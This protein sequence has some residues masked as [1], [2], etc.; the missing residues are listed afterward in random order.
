MMVVF[1][2][3]CHIVFLSHHNVLF[4]QN[5][6]FQFFLVSE[7]LQINA[8]LHT[9]TTCFLFLLFSN[10]RKIRI[11]PSSKRILVKVM[12]KVSRT[13]FTN[14]SDQSTWVWKI[15][16]EFQILKLSMNFKFC[17]SFSVTICA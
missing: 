2:V 14:S 9:V 1:Q 3:L 7:N 15:V 10:H 4:N 13:S 11:S 16:H 17:N 8:F 12:W 6:T 5:H